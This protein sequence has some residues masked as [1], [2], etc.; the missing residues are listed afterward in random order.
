[1]IAVAVAGFLI[2]FGKSGVAGTPGPFVTVLMALTLPADDAIGLLLPMLIIGDALTVMA[3]WKRWDLGVLRPLV[4]AALGG[5]AL[6]SLLISAISEPVLRRLIGVAMLIFAG[7]YAL[8]QR[9]SIPPLAL[10]R[11]AWVAGS[12]AG[13]TSTIAHLGGPPIVAYLISARLDPR[14]FVGT[15]A[16]FFALINI[17]KIPGYAFAGLF[18]L[19][20]ILSTIWAWVLIPVGVMTGRLLVDRIERTW[21][22]RVTLL[23]LSLGAILLLVT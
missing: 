9:L 7:G 22:E 5:I 8:T 18:D 3:Y 16:A 11:L 4:M 1:M 14:T 15:S 6:G 21:F 20:L 19:P 10:R 23:L 13:F 17:L 2:G 12:T